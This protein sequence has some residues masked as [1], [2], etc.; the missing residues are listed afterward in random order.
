M[1]LFNRNKEEKNNEATYEINGYVIGVNSHVIYHVP[2]ISNNG[3]YSLPDGALGLTST[4]IF[5]MRSSNPSKIIAKTF[6]ISP[7]S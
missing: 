7:L 4:A 2:K 1:G 3:T 6:I 5:E